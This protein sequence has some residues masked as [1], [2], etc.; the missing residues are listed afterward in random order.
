MLFSLFNTLVTFKKNI[1]KV[2]TEKLKMINI[3]YLHK[4]L[5]RIEDQS[6]PH[7]EVVS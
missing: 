3:I 7:F 1:G 4:I 6:L 2:L 5:I